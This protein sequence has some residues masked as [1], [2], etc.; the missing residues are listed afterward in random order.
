M[1]MHPVFKILVIAFSLTVGALVVWQM[2]DNMS[3][4]DAVTPAS[5]E[6]AKEEKKEPAPVISSTKNPS[7]SVRLQDIE[8]LPPNANKEAKRQAPLIPSF[9]PGLVMP[10]GAEKISSSRVST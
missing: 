1:K 7:G 2:K 4:D 9:K 10:P 6:T 8:N 5:K 3:G